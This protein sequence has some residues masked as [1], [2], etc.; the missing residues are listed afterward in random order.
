MGPR[1]RRA[2]LAVL[3][4]LVGGAGFSLGAAPAARA[5]DPVAGCVP[6]RARLSDEVA[7]TAG[8]DSALAADLHRVEQADVARGVGEP[9][10][11]RDLLAALDRHGYQWDCTTDQLTGDGSAPAEVPAFPA[12]VP[13]TTVITAP[14]QPQPPEA[15]SSVPG[16]L[17][18]FTATATATARS[19]SRSSP[20]LAPTVILLA[21][22]LGAVT[23][24]VVVFRRRA[25]L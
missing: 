24:A 16:Y 11:V 12:V 6:S 19:R 4:A 7:R 14:A 23:A 21:L 25:Q 20:S 2:S 8:P 15:V 22:A 10:V 13:A 18:G 9:Q 5:A 3:V 1:L 17:P